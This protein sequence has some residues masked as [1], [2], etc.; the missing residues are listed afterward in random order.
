VNVTNQESAYNL[1][2]SYRSGDMYAPKVE[3]IEALRRETEYFLSCIT[4]GEQPEND[5]HAGLR[6]VKL[7]DACNQSMKLNGRMVSV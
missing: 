4:K 1:R 5:G 6:V 7:L 3:Q 2:V